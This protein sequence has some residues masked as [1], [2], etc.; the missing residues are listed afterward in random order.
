MEVWRS[1]IPSLPADSRSAVGKPSSSADRHPGSACGPKQ[2]TSQSSR[3]P[4][5]GQSREECNPSAL[6]LVV[7]EHAG[8][9]IPLVA[10]DGRGL[11]TKGGRGVL[12]FF[13]LP[14]KR[15]K[16]LGVCRI[17]DV[18]CAVKTRGR[19]LCWGRGCSLRGWGAWV[20]SWTW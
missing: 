4:V 12:F 18:V 16:E 11:F 17:A 19:S 2:Q 3:Q 6:P 10:Q 8:G 14:S 9:D 5:R 15:R 13:F 7:R 1:V 20:C